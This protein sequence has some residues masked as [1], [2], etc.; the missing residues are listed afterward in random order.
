L[1]TLLGMHTD[2]FYKKYIDPK[3]QVLADA[4]RREAE[5]EDISL[6][7]A[8]EQLTAGVDSTDKT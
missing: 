5:S 6:Q 2:E 7:E 1:K 3:I 8:L 4:I